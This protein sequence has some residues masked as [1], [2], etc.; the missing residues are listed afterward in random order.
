MRMIIVSVVTNK[1]GDLSGKMDYRPLA[2][3]TT[4]IFNH[5]LDPVLK[6]HLRIHD[7]QFSFSADD[8]RMAPSYI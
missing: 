3:T 6:I 2:T 1:S 7:A 8:D 5:F 4:K